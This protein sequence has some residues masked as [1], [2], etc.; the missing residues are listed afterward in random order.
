[1]FFFFIKERTLER[2]IERL[3]LTHLVNCAYAL[4]S[5]RCCL[6][7]TRCPLERCHALMFGSPVAL[8]LFI[9]FG[10]AIN[11]VSFVSIKKSKTLV[12]SRKSALP[13]SYHAH[14]ANSNGLSNHNQTLAR[15][16]NHLRSTLTYVQLDYMVKSKFIPSH[17]HNTSITISSCWPN[18]DPFQKPPLGLFPHGKAN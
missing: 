11:L 3:I 13:C 1:M 4:Y 7:P 12:A 9:Y 2:C 15:F 17:D 10:N 16:R 5:L 8:C 6:G 14:T 18:F